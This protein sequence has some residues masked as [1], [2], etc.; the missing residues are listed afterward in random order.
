M[1]VSEK[2]FGEKEFLVPKKFLV[3]K[4]LL[5]FLKDKLGQEFDKNVWVEKKSVKKIFGQIGVN[6]LPL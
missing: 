5:K 3:K 6:L 2:I 1:F 4:S